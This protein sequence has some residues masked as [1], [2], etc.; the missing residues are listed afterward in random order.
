MVKKKGTM[1]DFLIWTLIGVVVLAG[2]I[3]AM[4]IL[5]RPGTGAIAYMKGLLKWGA[6]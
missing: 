2:A 1:V 3:W 6:S 4:I 5:S